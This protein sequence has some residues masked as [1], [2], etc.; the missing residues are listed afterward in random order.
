LDRKAHRLTGLSIASHMEAIIES[1]ISALVSILPTTLAGADSSVAST[2]LRDQALSTQAQDIEPPGA[3]DRL[4]HGNLARMTQ[5]VSLPG[6]GL[7]W[8]DWGMH[9]AQSPGKWWQL[10]DKARRKNLRWLDYVAR[11]STNAAAEP[12]IVPLA[13][14]R[15]FAHPAWQQWPYNV[16]QQAFLLNQQ[17]WHNATTGIGGVSKH[18]QDV[19]SFMA[20]QMLDQVSPVNFVATNPEVSEATV[21]EGGANFVRG[22]A[23]VLEDSRRIR[24]GTAPAGTEHFRPGHEVAATPGRVVFRNRLMELLQYSPTTA[25]VHAEPMLIVPAWIMKYYILDLSPTNSLVRHMVTQGHTVFMVSWH[26]PTEVDSDLGM[27]DYLHDGVNAALHCIRTLVPDE[28]INAVGY[29]LGGTLLSIAVAALARN[30]ENLIN[31]VTFLAAQTDFSEAGELMLFIDESQIDWLED[32]MRQQGFLDNRQMAGAFRALR[33]NDLGWSLVVNQYL[34]GRRTPM[35]DL[36]AWNADTTRLPFRMHSEYLRQLFL[37]NDLAGGRYLV[38]NRPVAL[39]DIRVPL[40]GVATVSDH[41]S[42]WRSVYKMHLLTSCDIDFVLTSGGHNAGIVSEPG[43]KG[44][45]YFYAQYAGGSKYVD[46]ARWLDQAQER[47]G[48]WWPA[49]ANWLERVSNGSM[50]DAREPKHAIDAAPG[51]YVLER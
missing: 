19:V 36:M 49:W 16:M 41:V 1:S 48:S 44:R 29:C 13:Q 24:S 25:T 10:L 45:H 21:R 22:L 33:S 4:L 30:A 46:P 47:D 34:L 2:L 32:L 43:H 15:R 38:N 7:A 9:L 17:W 14:D 6:L 20:R 26:N 8:M 51:L 37:N 28:P 11:A 23:N 40:F 50:V 35:S 31:S 3:F 12:C 42:P 27:D 18:H 39:S 5:G